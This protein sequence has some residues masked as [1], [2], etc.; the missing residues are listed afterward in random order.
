LPSLARAMDTLASRTSGCC[1]LS[2]CEQRAMVRC[3]SSGEIT[4]SERSQSTMRRQSSGPTWAVDAAF[5]AGTGKA[6]EVF[7]G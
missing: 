5:A 6:V 1:E 2:A 3:A 4:P 7:I